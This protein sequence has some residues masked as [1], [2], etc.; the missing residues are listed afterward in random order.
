MREGTSKLAIDLDR[1]A[2]LLP[3]KFKHISRA[4]EQFRDAHSAHTD[5]SIAVDMLDAMR[6]ATTAD[7]R[8]LPWVNDARNALFLSA[9]VLYARATKSDS[10]HRHRL[11]LN[12]YFNESEKSE[13]KWLC[14]LRD[15][16]LAHFGPG[17]IPNELPLHEEFILLPLDR[18][19]DSRVLVASRRSIPTG[20][21]IDRV[22]KQ[23]G[24][25][26]ICAQRVIEKRDSRLVGLIDK[27][28]NDQDFIEVVRS[29]KTDLDKIFDGHPVKDDLLSGDRLGMSPSTYWAT[30]DLG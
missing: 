19:A 29:C 15:K 12:P 4:I 20:H 22:T 17:A 9:V 2:S 18:P 28:M 7:P 14:D 3:E 27:S 1:V 30:I 23:V 24:R 11:D 10:D 8:E 16:A 5:L 25:S 6:A 13:H 26:M 21:T